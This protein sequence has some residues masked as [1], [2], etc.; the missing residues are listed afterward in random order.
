MKTAVFQSEKTNLKLLAEGCRNLV[1][2][3][4]NFWVLAALTEASF[5][6]GVRNQRFKR[7]VA[8]YQSVGIPDEL[9][10]QLRLGTNGNLKLV[11]ERQN[12]HFGNVTRTTGKGQ[13]LSYFPSHG[14]RETK[15]EVKLVYDC[16]YAKYYNSVADDWNKL[17]RVRNEGFTGDLFLVVFFTQL[18]CYDYPPGTSS[19]TQE[20]SLGRRRHLVNCGITAQYRE[21]LRRL[22][23]EPAWPLEAPHIH[24]LSL[25]TTSILATVGAWLRAD[26]I[27]D[28]PW[29]FVPAL[30]L[31][32]AAVGV[33][34]WQIP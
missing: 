19:R 3:F 31:A 7:Y 17:V 11:L 28:E 2:K 12:T 32:E 33:A 13:D 16:T 5:E 25:P 21:L 9:L 15:I 27:P 24:K 26:W 6:E 1:S 22:T 20:K 18:P 29:Q 8:S 14:N 4:T 30:H 23:R 10:T 34:I